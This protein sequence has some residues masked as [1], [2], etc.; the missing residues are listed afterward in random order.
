[1]ELEI[2]R[3]IMLA[4]ELYEIGTSRLRTSNDLHLFAAVNLMQDAVEVFLVAVGEHVGAAIDKYTKFDKYFIA[5]NEKIAPKELPF[6]AKIIRLN[7]IRV[8]SKH[9][10]IQPAR[11]ECERLAVSVREFFE[12][13]SSSLLEAPF[14]TLTGIDLLE[15]GEAKQMLAEAR[16][17]LENK[18]NE[19]CVIN[20]RKAI[21]LEIE[22]FYDIAAYKDGRP[23]D[24]LAGLTSAPGFA[25]N[26]EYIQQYVKDPT[27]FI[28]YD[29]SQLHQDLV[30]KGV[31]NT[32]FWNIWR[33]T[34]KVYQSEDGQWLVKHEFHKLSEE[35]LASNV[36]YIFA[37]TIDV[38]LAIH[39][40]RRGIRDPQ[41]GRSY[42]ELTQENVP[43][44]EKADLKSNIKGTT[45]PGM[46]QIDTNFR[47][48]GF[49]NDGPYWYVVHAEKDL[50]LS[51]YIHND[52][53]K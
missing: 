20:C 12:E 6:R 15:D 9:H 8:D 35:A 31:D 23:K 19:N 28:V 42:I 32:A 51:G 39:T 18:D 45:P 24:F 30:T 10:G 40:N 50:F 33:L 36:D 46:S 53:V 5:I 29:Y 21:F 41:F 11:D 34:P 17:A 1:M 22:R 13:V 25:R 37:A 14:S 48:D 49:S 2:V 26:K 4:R 3:R 16:I 38:L 44:F 27:D 47:V 7:L 43:I 52:Y